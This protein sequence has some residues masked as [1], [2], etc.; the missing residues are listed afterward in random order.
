[1]VRLLPGALGDEDS[2]KDD[3]FSTSLL[4]YLAALT[5]QQRFEMTFGKSREMASLCKRQGSRRA[6]Q[7]IKRA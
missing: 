6:T 2:A 4:E 5:T 3:S 7:I 1:V